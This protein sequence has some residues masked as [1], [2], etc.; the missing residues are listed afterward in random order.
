MLSIVE[1]FASIVPFA[2]FTTSTITGTK[3]AAPS[4]LTS[5]YSTKEYHEQRQRSRNVNSLKKK[6]KFKED[7]CVI[8][9]LPPNTQNQKDIKKAYRNIA[10]QYHPDVTVTISSTKEERKRANDEFAKINAAYSSLMGKGGIGRVGDIRVKKRRRQPHEANHHRP[11]TR[12]T[13]DGANGSAGKDFNCNRKPKPASSSTSACTR[14]R[15]TYG[16]TRSVGRTTNRD[17]TT[18]ASS[19]STSVGRTKSTG[20]TTNAGRN[21]TTSASL[22]HNF[23]G[24]S[25]DAKKRI[26]DE[27]EPNFGRYY[28]TDSSPPSSTTRSNSRNGANAHPLSYTGYQ[29]TSKS[30]SRKRMQRISKPRANTTPV[31]PKSAPS[32]L[33]GGT[34]TDKDKKDD[35][36]P[37]K[38][39]TLEH[40]NFGHNRVPFQ[41][42]K[43]TTT[44]NHGNSADWA[45]ISI[46]K[47]SSSSKSGDGMWSNEQSTKTRNNKSHSNI[48]RE[49]H[50]SS[51]CDDNNKNDWSTPIPVNVK[52]TSSTTKPKPKA[53]T[54]IVVKEFLN[55]AKRDGGSGRATTSPQTNPTTV[56]TA[57]TSSSPSNVSLSSSTTKKYHSSESDI[58]GVGA[59]YMSENPTICNMKKEG[60][61]GTAATVPPRQQNMPSKESELVIVYDGSK[62]STSRL[63]NSF[64]SVIDS[65]T[66]E[67]TA[68]SSPSTT[69][70]P[71]NTNERATVVKSLTKKR[72]ILLALALLAFQRVARLTIQQML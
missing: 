13:G 59:S 72:T 53:T 43:K 64:R 29:S 39:Q 57:S 47:T 1:G 24:T 50:V 10:R 66:N 27:D 21:T 65:E 32:H 9:N 8:L 52:T 37:S 14:Q 7:P 68:S 70:S 36:F 15:P 45:S 48:H 35:E 4:H 51:Q 26:D 60:R 25:T 22:Y 33:F 63:H 11:F 71:K 17:R 31:L 69:A 2:P 18:S 5:L 19:R 38:H 62:K 6:I 41:N 49:T 12:G 23:G 55:L 30:S 46:R 67:N 20:R 44:A 3:S 28:G 40:S 58:A 54:N 34:T 16:S 61:P 56:N 42:Q